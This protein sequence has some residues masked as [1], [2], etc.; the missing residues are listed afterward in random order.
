MLTIHVR[1]AES[2]SAEELA[3]CEA[4]WATR[5]PEGS[6]GS[7]DPAYAQQRLFYVVV[8]V[9]GERIGACLVLERTV[10]VD[11]TPQAIAGLSDVL[12][13]EAWRGR[14]YG[15][16]MIRAAMDEAARRGYRQGMLFC[17]AQRA[18]YERLGWVALEGETTT[19]QGGRE[20]P[21]QPGDW[22]MIVPL[23]P[24][25]EAEL[26]RWVSARVGVGVG[27]W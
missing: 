8:C 18:F 19:L 2:I 1:D 5:W 23:T 20:V 27:Q 11:G 10:R 24:E 22:V 26:P 12:L 15:T 17:R 9:A 7:D 21:T 13:R 6:Y 3:W 4:L 25:A 14:G 16:R